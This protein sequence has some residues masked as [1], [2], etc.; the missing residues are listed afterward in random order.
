MAAPLNPNDIRGQFPI[1]DQEVNGNP[2]VYLDSAATTQKPRAVIDVIVDYYERYNSN[3]HRGVHTLSQRATDA[4]EKARESVR[5]FLNAPDA[6]DIVFVRGTT[7]AV[8]LVAHSFVRPRLS[9]G[10]EIVISG[11]EHH[12][13]IVPWQLI[14]EETGAVLKPV[15]FNDA[16]ELDLAAFEEAITEKTKFVSLVH[17]S[18]SLGTIN[19]VKEVVERAHSRGVPVFLDGAQAAG[20]EAVDVQALDCDFYAISGHKLYGPTGIGALYG[21]AEVLESMQPYQGGGEMITRVTFEDTKFHKVPH[22]FEAGTPNIVGSIGLGAAIEWVE[23][24]G[25]ENIA[26][27]EHELLEYATEALSVFGDNIRV[28]GTAEKKAGILSFVVENAHPHDV[29]TILDQEGVAVRAG[30]HCAQ[31]VMQRYDVAATVRASFAVYNT[32]E[33][34]DA[35]VRALKKVEEIFGACPT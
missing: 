7:E 31:P 34:V 30:H 23:S 26:A 18:N 24:V 25:I 2:L 29:G 28:I 27:Y 3:I 4:Y 19:P 14:L 16:G 21:K 20:H 32:R 22:R 15:P 10:D 9:P 6:K 35:L 13:N 8:N 12:S 33:D 17:V 11:M 5:R 1:L